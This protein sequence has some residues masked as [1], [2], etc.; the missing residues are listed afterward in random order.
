MYP[1]YYNDEPRQES[2]P[3]QREVTGVIEA[4]PIL[5]DAYG[6]RECKNSTIVE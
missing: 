2:P 1:R 4:L 6:M 3:R 5:L